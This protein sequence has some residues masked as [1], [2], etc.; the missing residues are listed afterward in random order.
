MNLDNMTLENLN[1]LCS[2]IREKIIDVVLKNGGHLA[3]N[4]G[5]VELTVA[6]KKVFSDSKKNRIL[7][8]VGHQ[9]YVY[10]ILT[11]REENFST[12]RTYK[13]LG[14]FLDPKESSEDYFISGHA[15]SA[16]SAGCG[17]AYAEP[18]VRVIVVVGDASIA[19]GHSLE[20]LNNMGN[21]KNMIV[22]LND[23][24]MSIGKSVGSLSNFFSR[25][26]SSRMYMNVKKD[27]KNIIDRG[28]FGRKVKNTLGRAEHSIKNF[29]LPMSISEN[30]GFKYFGVVDGHNME[31][32]LNIFRKSKGN[33]RSCLYTCEN[34]KRKGI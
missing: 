21:L 9:G 4:L 15:G 23:N 6:L 17:I 13:G 1:K 16:L 30:L 18:E 20:A 11:G 34:K 24:D 31:E 3:S 32:L 26:I 33:R 27:V 7:F 8:D 12:L 2:D 19:N 25:M 10:K 28:K 22:V 29:F 5:V 14:P